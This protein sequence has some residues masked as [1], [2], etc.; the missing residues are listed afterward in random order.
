MQEDKKVFEENLNF[1]SNQVGIQVLLPSIRDKE[2]ERMS[3]ILGHYMQQENHQGNAFK[4]SLLERKEILTDVM[5][6]L[7]EEN[8]F[9]VNRSIFDKV[10]RQILFTILMVIGG[11]LGGSM[12]V[13]EFTKKTPNKKIVGIGGSMAVFADIISTVLIIKFVQDE[14]VQKLRYFRRIIG[15]IN[16][17]QNISNYLKESTL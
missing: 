14:N 9:F 11:V 4:L 10:N 2:K 1:L 16:F 15:Q 17:L 12:A 6:Q 13:M 3:N 8:P 5:I 7:A